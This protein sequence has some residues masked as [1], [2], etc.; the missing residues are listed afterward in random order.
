MCEENEIRDDC[1][2]EICRIGLRIAYFL[3]VR[4]M[5][6]AELAEKVNINKNYLSHIECGNANKSIS[7]P[8]LIRISKVLNVKLAVLVDLDDWS[9]DAEKTSEA[10]V[11]QELKQ[12]FN[13]MC[14]MNAELDKTMAKMDEW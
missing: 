6:Q 7:L 2:E 8:L 13:E 14:Q 12:M 11:V 9:D 5:T 10:V 1:F 3:K 4:N